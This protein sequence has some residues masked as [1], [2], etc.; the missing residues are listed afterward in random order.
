MPERLAQL[1]ST[2]V[3]AKAFGMFAA[4]ASK[5]RLA[6]VYWA[7]DAI[8]DQ[9]LIK[10]SIPKD[11]TSRVDFF[12]DGKALLAA[13]VKL[14]PDLVVL[15]LNMPGMDGLTAFGLLRETYAADILPVVIFSTAR[16]EAEEARCRALGIVAYV[17]KPAQ[18]A[19]FSKAVIRILGYASVQRPSRAP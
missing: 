12:L 6:R 19:V 7:E 4:G 11:T 3:A 5:A 1:A 9:Y 2:I 15:D 8:D 14:K 13:V 10:E 17:Q 18:F 16:N